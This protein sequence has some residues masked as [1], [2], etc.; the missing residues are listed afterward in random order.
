MPPVKRR[1]ARAP[2]A[3]ESIA[4]NAALR[5]HEV[6]CTMVADRDTVCRLLHGAMGSKRMMWH[7]AS[8]A[9][10]VQCESADAMVCSHLAIFARAFRVWRIARAATL[11]LPTKAL[12][13]CAQHRFVKEWRLEVV[14]TPPSSRGE[15]GGDDARPRHRRGYAL[16][17][18]PSADQCEPDAQWCLDESDFNQQ[19][20]RIP[21]LFPVVGG[22]LA[23]TRGFYMEANCLMRYLRRAAFASDT[24]FMRV[25]ARHLRVR[26]KSA[27]GSVRYVFE[28]ERP[29]A[30]TTGPLRPTTLRAYH[31]YTAQSLLSMHKA[32]QGASYVLVVQDPQGCLRVFIDDGAGCVGCFVVLSAP[33]AS[34]CSVFLARDDS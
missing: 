26:A 25:S 1:R 11:C 12:H 24:I 5:R 31:R 9:L 29:L 21:G 14:R 33:A 34:S 13:H 17:I 18:R 8:H 10:H 27:L 28:L 15:R 20:Y 3:E 22:R 16:C 32:I 19:Y 4:Q 6:C 7:V 23:T 30:R 2:S